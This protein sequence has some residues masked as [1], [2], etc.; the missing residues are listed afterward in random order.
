MKKIKAG[1]NYKKLGRKTKLNKT[2]LKAIKLNMRAGIFEKF[3]YTSLS[4]P[5]ATWY[6]WKAKAGV[7]R[8]DI[9]NGIKPKS[10]NQA[11]EWTILVDFLDTTETTKA[12]VIV[13]LTGRMQHVAQ[14]DPKT[15]KFMLQTLA[16]EEYGE[17][18]TLNLKHTVDEKLVGRMRE[19]HKERLKEMEEK[20]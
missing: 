10:Q 19:A 15:A 3:V 17:T 6:S 18:D 2:L 11:A 9:E 14:T 16:K 13:L 8:Q 4:I 5:K 12:K 20:E 7:I 1:T